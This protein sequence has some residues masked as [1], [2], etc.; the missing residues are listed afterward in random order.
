MYTW[1]YFILLKKVILENIVSV[2]TGY[3][4]RLDCSIL[5]LVRNCHATV[6]G[7]KHVLTPLCVVHESVS[8]ACSS[9]INHCA[10]KV[11]KLIGTCVRVL[12]Y[13]VKFV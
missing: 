9:N 12:R 5:S 3:G 7:F 13:T 2:N 6:V 4:R 11:R 10:A 8:W 1:V